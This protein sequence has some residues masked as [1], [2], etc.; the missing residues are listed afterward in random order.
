MNVEGSI[1]FL[2]AAGWSLH[3]P[4]PKGTVPNVT[5]QHAAGVKNLIAG[6]Q[7]AAVTSA[8]ESL[9]EAKA[10]PENDAYVSLDPKVRLWLHRT[11]TFSP[12]IFFLLAERTVKQACEVAHPAAFDD[13]TQG[14]R[15]CS[16]GRRDVAL[17]ISFAESS[18]SGQNCLTLASRKGAFWAC[19]H[20]CSC[21]EFAVP[22]SAMC[23]VTA[24]GRGVAGCYCQ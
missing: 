20:L 9:M 3:V 4:L 15:Y 22:K 8:V 18:R 10:S 2:K 6:E 12:E 19:R 23:S 24:S 5:P 17:L 11:T 14:W 21:A 7:R 13:C 1:G 16:R